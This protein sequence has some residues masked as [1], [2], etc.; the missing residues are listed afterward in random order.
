MSLDSTSI[1]DLFKK[2]LLQWYDPA[3]RP[4]PW[5]GETDPYRIWISEVILQQT[6]VEQGWEYY[7]RFVAKYPNVF[8]L[9]NAPQEDVLRLWQGLGYYSR[10]RN[11]HKGA[12]QIVEKYNCVIP[13]DLK[14]I[15]EISS[16]GPYTAAAIASFA[17][18]LPHAVMDGNVIRII[19]RLFGISEA[20]DT[21][22]GQKLFRE[23]AQKLID[24]HQPAIYNQAIMDFGATVCTPSLPKCPECP[25]NDICIAYQTGNV[26]E[27]PVKSKKI[28]KKDRYFDYLV[29]VY[30]DKI[31][32]EKRENKDVY[33]DMYEF[34]LQEGEKPMN[35]NNVENRI[36][37]LTGKKYNYIKT[38]IKKPHILTHQRLHITFYMIQVSEKP[39]LSK[40]K[41]VKA[42]SIYSLPFP[43]YISQYL[44]TQ[45][46]L[47]TFIHNS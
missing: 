33:K 11:L 28:K 3:A 1:K 16:V 14:L 4:M 41:W 25:M 23:L 5:K 8:D 10:A 46:F 9:A 6:R 19:A 32:L 18:G 47:P 2:I 13:P 43:N 12:K 36:L 7:N 31:Y 35:D 29:L 34:I 30:Q 20:F 39:S 26:A 37:S 44:M 38:E 17:F 27:L 22:S 45:S 40:G 24:V 15:Q 21:T 42:S